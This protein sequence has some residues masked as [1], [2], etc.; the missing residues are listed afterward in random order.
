MANTI[1]LDGNVLQISAI[2]TDWTWSDT[3]PAYKYPNGIKIE[4]IRFDTAASTDVCIIKQVDGTGERLFKASGHTVEAVDEKIQ[5]FNGVRLKPFL[6]VGDGV[7]NA[8]ASVTI[9]LSGGI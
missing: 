2:D 9:I 4:S 7:Y 6:D 3:F 5:Y 8:A 1:S